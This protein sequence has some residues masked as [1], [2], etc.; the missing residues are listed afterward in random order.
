MELHGLLLIDKPPGLTSHDVVNQARRI[1]GIREV[2]HCGTLDPIATG[3]LILAVGEGVK[4]SSLVTHWSKSYQGEILFGRA[5][6]SLDITGK[7]V[8]EGGRPH[9]EEE[10]LKAI[11]QV[12]GTLTLPVPRYSATKVGGECLYQKAR[13]GEE[14]QPPEKEMVFRDIRSLGYVESEGRWSFILQ[15]E[16]GSY[17]RSWVE[18]LGSVLGYPAVL[19]DLKRVRAGNYGVEQ[20]LT[21]EKLREWKETGQLPNL[22]QH[23]AWIPLRA[24]LPEWWEVRVDGFDL[25]LIRNGQISKGLRSRL[26]RLY[27]PDRDNF[28]GFKVVTAQPPFFLVALVGLDKGK[29]FY[30]KR[31]FLQPKNLELTNSF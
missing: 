4:I 17:V 22:T 9:S 20:A 31:G 3:L 26:I 18:R 25:H 2:G 29:G 7:I 12:E 23:S 10:I 15:C 13:R 14:F 5:T 21:L 19:S 1:L 27:Q 6:D 8:A 24:A 30:I 16:K 11:P 28:L